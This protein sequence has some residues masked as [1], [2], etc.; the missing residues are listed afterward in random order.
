MVGNSEKWYAA[1]LS[2][3]SPGLGLGLHQVPSVSRGMNPMA[4][5]ACHA[6]RVQSH[7]CLPWKA[8]L[9]GIEMA[10]KVGVGCHQSLLPLLGR[11][12]NGAVPTPLWLL[13]FGIQATQ[14]DFV[15]REHSQGGVNKCCGSPLP[16]AGFSTRCTDVGTAS[17]LFSQG[18]QLF[19]SLPTPR[20]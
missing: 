1:P 10:K 16:R 17:C 12:S 19:L 15:K 14:G 11:H 9:V 13:P 18:L 7:R 2:H 5:P 20:F 6:P 4:L 8:R 3:F